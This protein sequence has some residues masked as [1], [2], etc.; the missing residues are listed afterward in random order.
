MNSELGKEKL[1]SM[2]SSPYA[3]KLEFVLVIK[4]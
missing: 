2:I 3:S 4:P 1:E